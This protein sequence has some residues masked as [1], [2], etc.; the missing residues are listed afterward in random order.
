MTLCLGGKDRVLDFGK[1]YFTKFYGEAAGSDPLNTTDISINPSVQFD[2]VV[3]IVYAGMKTHCKAEKVDIDFTREDVEDWIGVKETVEV[4]EI[5][6]EY[7][8]LNSVVGEAPA[9]VNGA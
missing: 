1:W 8:S 6:T 5:I 7:A 4:Q 3:N 9:P 2:F